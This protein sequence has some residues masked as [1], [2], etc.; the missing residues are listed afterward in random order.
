MDASFLYMETPTVHLHVVGVLIIDPTDAPDFSVEKLK[1]VL[2]DRMHLIKPFRRRLVEVPFRLGRPVWIED[3]GFDIDQHIRRVAVPGPG[4]M[5]ELAEL[6]GDIASRPLDRSMALWEMWF[7]EGLEG[8]K[9][10]LVSKMHHAAID[11]VSGAD[12]MVHLFDLTPEIATYD[13]PE[14]PWQPEPEPSDLRMVLDAMAASVSGPGR[15]LKTLRDLAGAVTPVVGALRAG[16]E[17][18]RQSPTL[19]FTAPRTPW[20]GALTPHRAVAFSGC[21]LDDMKRIK[22]AFGCTVNDVVLACATGALRDWLKEHGGVPDVPLV[23]SCPVSVRGE[24][25]ADGELGNKVSSMFVSLPVQLDDPVERIEFVRENTKGAKELHGAL[26]AETIMQ[27]AEAAPPALANLA[28]RLYSSTK[29]ADRHRPV[30]NLVVSNVPGPPIP[31]Y[32]AGARVVATYPMGPI[33][34][35][36]GM[37]ITVLS[38][39]GNMDVGIIACRELVPDVW[40]LANGFVQHVKVLLEAAEKV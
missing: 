4:S 15:T 40:D 27:L 29:L 6:V 8:G 28:A 25:D 20:N 34:E 32:C 16:R 5:H 39:M 35:G 21:A 23:V 7:V 3:E 13:P 26:G 17:P 2:L 31:L 38:N 10:A 18:D 33:L 14:E 24:P 11:G 22:V 19:P 30:Q 12:L 37:N 36:A 1:S 9:V